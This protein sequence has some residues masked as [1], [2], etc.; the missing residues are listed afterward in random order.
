MMRRM[1]LIAAMLLLSGCWWSKKQAVDASL[2]DIDNNAAAIGTNLDDA[3]ATGDVGPAA[4]PKVEDSIARAGAIREDCAK[5]KKALTGVEDK[6]NLLDKILDLLPWI[7]AFALLIYFAPV[8]KP[9]LTW[10]RLFIPKPK[11]DQA[12]LM[13]EAIAAEE[14]T[15]ENLTRYV[16]SR[17]A[18]DPAFRKVL[19]TETTKLENK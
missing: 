3:L 12:K 13:A 17:K 8:V 7:I 10:L 19:K 2:T 5:G 16:E 18:T 14:V 4:V 15:G 9:I 1:M 11:K 6:K